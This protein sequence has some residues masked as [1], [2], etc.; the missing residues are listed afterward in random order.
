MLTDDVLDITG[1]SLEPDE[2]L[3]LNT[4]IVT[5][6]D[7]VNRYE[8][9]STFRFIDG[10][11][12]SDASL[13]NIIISSGI[14]NIEDPTLST[15]KEYE[16]IP[17]FSNEELN[18]EIEILEYIDLVNLK[19][20]LS[21]EN[22]S[23]KLKVPKRDEENNLIYDEDGITI[24]YEEK[25]VDVLGNTEIILNKLGEQ[26]TEIIIEVTAEDGV[27]VKEYTVKIRK[28]YGI[29]KGKSILADFDNESIVNNYFE[30]YGVEINN[31]STVNIYNKDKVEWKKIL[32]IYSGE[33]LTYEEI[34]SIEKV[35][36]SKTDLDGTFEIYVIPG[37]YDIQVTRL[38]YLDYV[39]DNVIINENDVIDMG[40]VNLKAGDIDRNG[41]I[42][43]E[44]VK[45]VKS[46]MGMENTDSE[47]KE[48]WNPTQ[49]GAVIGEDLKYVKQNMDE[50][51]QIEYF[52]INQ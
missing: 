10:T 44:D 31:Q 17:T 42:A 25:E 51:F 41:V 27:T 38:A 33:L 20:E 39:Y 22:A 19:L 24:L 6:I 26:D 15:Y 47:F 2:E 32:N 48:N 4:G 40:I 18:Y 50:I 1:F 49:I 30:I 12:S 52:Q 28:P 45:L 23:V 9:E 14:E 16:L 37:E 43:G 21:D 3:A 5:N 36:S 29:I 11:A 34:E 8:A 13:S 35:T 7:V 46:V